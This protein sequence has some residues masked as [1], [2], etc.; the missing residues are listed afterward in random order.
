VWL[1]IAILPAPVKK[2][3]GWRLIEDPAG[4]FIV[5]DGRTHKNELT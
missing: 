2:A 5:K 1:P 3:E 4:N